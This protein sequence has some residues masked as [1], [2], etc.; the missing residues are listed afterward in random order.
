L[1]EAVSRCKRQQP[2]EAAEKR[3][4]FRPDWTSQISLIQLDKLAF[5]LM[6]SSGRQSRATAIDWD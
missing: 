1:L 6:R 5:S 3:H 2:I 4:F